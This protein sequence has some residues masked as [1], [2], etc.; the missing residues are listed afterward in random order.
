[1]LAFSRKMTYL[2]AVLV[3]IA[4]VFVVIGGIV[5]PYLDARRS[6]IEVW[7]SQLLQEPIQIEKARVSWFQY[8]PGVA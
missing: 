7:A 1:M 6:D 8:Q 3:I 2:T 5:T 4:A